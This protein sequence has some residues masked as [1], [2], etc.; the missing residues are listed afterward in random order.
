MS[1]GFRIGR[2]GI[3]GFKG[4]TKP[5]EVDL[6]NRHVFL[7]GRNGNGKSSVIEAIRWGLFGSTNRP[8]DIVANS[9]YGQ[10]CQ[11]EISL[12][13]DGNEWQLRRTLIRGASGGSHT[14]LLDETG[15]ERRISDIM[16]QLDSLDAGEGTHIESVRIYVYG[17][18][19][20]YE[21]KKSRRT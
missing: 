6:R 10:R 12:L 15:Q 2:I 7:L 21:L 3:E 5:Q 18:L 13:R 9:E 11:V 8:N 16:P 17:N 4:F 20:E 14:K 1:D 19:R